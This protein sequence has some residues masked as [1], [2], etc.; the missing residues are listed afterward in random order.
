MG[1]KR[2]SRFDLPPRV[3]EHH[4]SYW[5]RPRY[6]KPINLGK[7][8]P[9]AKLKWAELEDPA[10][11]RGS[12]ASLLDWYL[13]TVAP[14]K[15]PRT[16]ADNLKEAVFLKNGLGHIPFR[17]LRPHHVATYR[18]ARAQDAPVR[19]N[20]EKALLSHV[21]TKA[22]ERGWV[23]VNPCAG[24]KRNSES[25]RER[26][27]EDEEFWKVYNLAENS[28]QRLMMLI[29]RTAQ[30]P[31]DL[32]KCGPGNIKKVRSGDKE[33]KV[34]RITQ[35]KTGATVDVR[36]EGDLEDLVNECLSGKIVHSHFVHTRQ[37]KR[38]TYSGI[39][40]MFTRYVKTSLVL[41]FGMYDL[42]GKAATDMYR[43]NVPLEQIQHL[44][45]HKSVTTTER[46]IKARMPSLVNSNKVVMRANI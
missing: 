10:N 8:L 20:R 41:D 9:L 1:R 37:G 24:V 39:T 16:Y 44:L 7:D 45:G 3:Y 11:E 26:Y 43:S 36:I 32:L 22:I 13:S 15:A 28:V 23:D 25:K 27:I 34:L 40:S 6:D 31:E 21:F 42:K 29:Y 18:D 12:L 2:Q 14:K 5:Y 46:Y 19:A 38:Y 4:G 35:D 17:Q 30:R 33:I